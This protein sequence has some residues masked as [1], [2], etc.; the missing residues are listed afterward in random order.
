[1]RV[2]FSALVAVWLFGAAQVFAQELPPFPARNSTISVKTW[3]AY[4]KD[5]LRILFPTRKTLVERISM[6]VLPTNAVYSGTSRLCI[7]VTTGLIRVVANK[8]EYAAALAHE[9]GHLL[10]MTQESPYETTGLSESAILGSRVV[11]WPTERK[12]DL[13][14]DFISII[15]AFKPHAAFSMLN[16]LI[17]SQVEAS[18]KSPAEYRLALAASL[19]LRHNSMEYLFKTTEREGF[20]PRLPCPDLYRTK[21]PTWQSGKMTLTPCFTPCFRARGISF[22]RSRSKRR[23]IQGILRPYPTPRA[24]QSDSTLL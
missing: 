4:S 6:N 19:L 12:N 1:M 5:V 20:A 17:P 13:E 3:E 2:V 16:R 9:M 14:A 15:S 22:R 10:C 18:M 23:L 7:T 11:D 21:N 8:D 24:L